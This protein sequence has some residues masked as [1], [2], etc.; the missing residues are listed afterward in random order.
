MSV[1]L[2]GGAAVKVGPSFRTEKRPRGCMKN[3]GQ[4]GW[5]DA[6]GRHLQTAGRPLAL[7]ERWYWIPRHASDMGAKTSILHRA[8]DEGWAPQSVKKIVKGVAAC[9]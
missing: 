7:R 3:P 9:W 8:A 6:A 2:A 4:V 5:R 1:P